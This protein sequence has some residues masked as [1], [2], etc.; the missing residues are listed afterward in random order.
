MD[1]VDHERA[2]ERGDDRVHCD[3]RVKYEG[4]D[5]IHDDVHGE[6]NFADGQRA[7]F[8]AHHDADDVR[9]AAGTVTDVEKAAADT[10]K[11]TA[12]DGVRERI[13]DDRFLRDRKE[14]HQRTFQKN[15]ET[16]LDH[17][18]AAEHTPAE[19]NDRY[20]QDKVKD[21]PDVVRLQGSSLCQQRQQ[22]GNTRKPAGI[23]SAGQNEEVDSETVNQGSDNAD[24]EVGDSAAHGSSFVVKH[25]PPPSTYDVTIT[26]YSISGKSVSINEVRFSSG[27]SSAVFA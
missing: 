27:L 21:T 12:D 16:R 5:S 26:E 13:R 2:A 17:R 14:G 22:L 3:L 19:N 4:T 15:R 10:F 8:L 7:V 24:C 25:T 1:L 18:L 6:G 20:V 9:A 23:Q 11:E